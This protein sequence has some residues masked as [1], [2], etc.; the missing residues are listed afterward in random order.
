MVTIKKSKPI[1]KIVKGDKMKIDGK[2]YEV[3][4]HS[5]MIDHGATKEMSID[6]FDP[7]AK[8]DEGDFQIRY[9]NDQVEATIGFFELKG[10]LYESKE[11]KK[12]EW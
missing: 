5:V 11:I 6:V 2:E 8:D 1:G 9:F 12:I 7:K 4:V 3:D 10:I